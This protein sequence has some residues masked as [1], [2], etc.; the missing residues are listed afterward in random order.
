MA[1]GR[2]LNQDIAKELQILHPTV[3]LF[4]EKLQDF[5]AL[6]LNP[7][8]KAFI[9]CVN[10]KSHIHALERSQPLLPFMSRHP[11][12]ENSRLKVLRNHNPLCSPEYA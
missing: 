11:A 7:P 3:Q 12:M 1:A 2:K 9:S 4:V 6:Y 8:D 10:E 5:V